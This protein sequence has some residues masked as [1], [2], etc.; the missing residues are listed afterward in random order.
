[1]YPIVNKNL[2]MY[3]MIEDYFKIPLYLY[4]PSLFKL[5]QAIIF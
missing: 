4:F 3:L 5:F 2:R 1:M